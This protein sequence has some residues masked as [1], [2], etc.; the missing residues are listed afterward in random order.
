MRTMVQQATQYGGDNVH[1]ISLSRCTYPG[2]SSSDSEDD[3][4]LESYLVNKSARW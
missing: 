4:S 1:G 3:E 2:R